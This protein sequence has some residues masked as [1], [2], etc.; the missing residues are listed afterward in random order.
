MIKID[1][2]KD[3]D[4]D[5]KDLAALR[6][7]KKKPKSNKERIPKMNPNLFG[8]IVISVAA[9]VGFGAIFSQMQPNIGAQASSAAFG[10]LFI[11]LSTKFLME[12]ES[13]NKLKNEKANKVFDANLLDY[14]NASLKMLKI[15]ENNTITE[16]EI[17]ELLHSLADLIIFGSD[18]SRDAFQKFIGKSQSIFEIALRNEDINSIDDDIVLKKEDSIML[19]EHIVDFQIA[20]R[21]GL[22]LDIKGLN[23]DSLNKTFQ[24]LV[25][26][27][28]TI[29]NEIVNQFGANEWL[30]RKGLKK[31]LSVDDFKEVEQQLE[32]LIQIIKEAGLKE[33]IAKTQISFGNPKY[34]NK[35]VI[36]LNNYAKSKEIFH[37]TFQSTNNRDFFESWKTKFIDFNP[38]I[39]PQKGKYEC[40]MAFYVNSENMKDPIIPKILKAYME[41]FHK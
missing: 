18:S 1:H 13:E 34:N 15:M 8:L 39:R 26:K 38:S 25:N 29:D 33:T 22:D 35:K 41:E 9:F 21:E 32:Y 40:D 28:D 3:G 14:K 27:Q 11:L 7:K 23:V 17:H 6:A 12:K 24:K 20:S 2:D 10:A 16:K 19:W 5:G 30:S 31:S 37:L 4:I 36:Y